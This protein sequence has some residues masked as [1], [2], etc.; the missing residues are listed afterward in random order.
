MFLPSDKTEDQQRAVSIR[1]IRTDRARERECYGSPMR[2]RALMLHR[3][4]TGTV[5]M[6][7]RMT[8]QS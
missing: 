7:V 2:D 4:N 6:P 8:D 1:T 5:A 3:G